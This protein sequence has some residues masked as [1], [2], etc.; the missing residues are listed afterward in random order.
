MRKLW[1]P[2][3]IVLLVFV[4]LV[5]AVWGGW[6]WTTRRAISKTAGSVKLDGLQAPVEIVRDQY[7]VAHVYAETSEDLFF[8][9]GYVHAQERFWQ[10]EFQ[11]RIGAGRL[12]EIFGKATLE[13]DLYLRHFDF[14]RLS[15]QA[16]LMM[17]DETK[18]VVDA[19]TAG[20]NAYIAS[21]S[22]AD[23]GLEFAL[24]GLQGVNFK[25]EPWT[26]AD[27]LVWSEMMIFD[28]GAR[29]SEDIHNFELL[30]L[31]GEARYAELRTDYRAD[32]PTIIPPG[33]FKVGSS[34]FSRGPLPA[35]GPDLTAYLLGEG[36]RLAGQGQPGEGLPP[37][38]AEL[39]L[40]SQAG[41]NSFVVGG[42]RSAT[43]MP[44]IA[45]DPHMGINVPAL[46]YEIGMHCKEKSA[47]C[48]YD[49]RGFSLPGVPGILIG[50]ND[51]IAWS[52]TNASFDAEDVF[53]EKVN[54]ADPN[55]YEVNGQWV[56][57]EIRREEVKV[58]GQDP[59]VIFVRS[60][61]NGVVASDFM[62][63]N[64]PFTYDKNGPQ[65]Y[66]LS[67]AWTALEPV[68][69]AQAVLMV[70]RAENWQQFVEA[71]RYFDAGK[72]NWLYADVE[73]NIGYV[74]PGKVPIRA[75]GDGTLP[76]PGWNDEYRWKGFIPYD[77]M[78]HL[79]NPQ[80]GFIV[81]ANNPQLRLKEYPYLLSTG[82]DRGQRAAR[83]TAL[84]LAD[85]DGITLADMQT[86]QTDNQSLG[87]LEVLPYL[88][89]LA[90]EDKKVT[91][92][93]D[94]LLAWDGQMR[95]ESPEAALFNLFWVDLIQKTYNDQLPEN[96]YP[97]G[98]ADTFD[99][100]AVLL[101]GPQNPW[102]DNVATTG[103]EERDE[104]LKLAFE[105]A[106]KSGVDRFGSNLDKWAWGK[107]HTILFRH[108]TLGSSGIA[109]IENIFNRGPFPVHGSE[110]VVDKIGW[111]A[112]SPY[113]ADSI[114]ALRQVIDLGNLD[115]SQMVQS[116][117]QSGHPYDPHYGDFIEAWRTFQYYPSNWSRASAESGVHTTLVLEP[118]K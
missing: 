96:Q 56:D 103:L 89:E 48:G 32:R 81:T 13:G 109:F 54:P 45:N 11:R 101:A 23:L 90:F 24:L 77:E 53:I 60:T 107:L 108:A 26:P 69:S 51:R 38:L 100:M 98:G 95:M 4:A 31:V 41:S 16:Y 14:Y 64:K 102:W 28:Q 42:K 118:S 87:A 34:G 44:L 93:R 6:R 59:V 57:M 79:L 74:L 37:L 99:S 19:Y 112:S 78:P 30:A 43:G 35:Y 63:S 84:I 18:K 114:P 71:L 67:F 12:S 22:P 21:R 106:Y 88:K 52:L 61:R 1:K 3:V 33:A 80:Q 85:V 50:H 70:N 46:W 111:D 94:R 65:P 73:G 68:R 58:R 20:V 2:L 75:G 66:V 105:S 7:G 39:G 116:F 29:P 76:V 72:Q 27:S 25:V 40:Q 47:R 115:N 49:F 104:I 82:Q 55:Q 91:A 92:A 5:L 36:E 86:F 62:V 113:A 9:E 110:A 83:L 8:A 10:M 97:D 17:D 117:G 15:E